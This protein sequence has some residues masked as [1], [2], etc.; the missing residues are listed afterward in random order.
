MVKLWVLVG[1][2][3]RLDSR[4]EG[5]VDQREILEKLYLWERVLWGRERDNAAQSG[6]DWRVCFIFSVR[7]SDSD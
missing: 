3:D 1:E 5:N 2:S 4:D 7:A 6:E